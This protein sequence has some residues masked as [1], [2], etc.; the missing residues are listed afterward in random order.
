[1]IVT[2]FQAWLVA[3]VLT[4][5]VEVPLY[6]WL[7]P[8]GWLRGFSL[9]LVTHPAVWY[10]IPPLCYRNGLHYHQML[11]IAEIFAWSVEAGMLMLYGVR[12]YRALLVALLV[13]AASVLAGMAARA[14]L[15][16]P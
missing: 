6:R 15:G 8:V 7:A 9:S 10:V 3:F 11:W 1:M 5:I 16:M 12:W 2:Y 4:Q 13:N 14:W